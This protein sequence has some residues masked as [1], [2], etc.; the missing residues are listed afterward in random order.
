MDSS[1]IKI[2]A[3]VCSFNRVKKT[4]L[5][6]KSLKAN[7]VGKNVSLEIFLVDDNSSDGTSEQVGIALPDVKIF[8][9][10]GNLYWAGA[11]RFGYDRIRHKRFDYLLVFND[12]VV[13]LK[14][15]CKNAIKNLFELRRTKSSNVIL[16]GACRGNEKYEPTYG[17]LD[18][19]SKVHPLRFHKVKPTSHLQEVKSLNMN[20]A[21]ISRETLNRN[22]FLSS[23]FIH[24]GAD[25][26]YGLR[27]KTGTNIKLLNEYVGICE[28][29]NLW[30]L[31]FKRA[32]DTLKGSD[33]YVL[34]KSNRLNKDFYT[35]AN[36]EVF[37]GPLLFILPYFRALLRL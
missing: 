2:I 32:L 34:L 11:M 15:G 3:L 30:A 14:D 27:V 7:F 4:L 1:E 21:L 17:G 25:V 23:W 13:F 6:L 12:D 8:R 10:T 31:L 16:V 9:G 28:A 29:N 20:F 33:D 36:M 18:F 19:A 37:F 5:A 26:E 35:T 24:G 22:G